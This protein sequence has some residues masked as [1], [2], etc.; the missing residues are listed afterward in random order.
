MRARSDDHSQREASPPL[1]KNRDF[2]RFFVGQFVTNAGDSLYSVAILWAVFELSGSTFLT[3]AANSLLLLPFLLQI[4]AGPLIDRLPIKHVL[5]GT[6]VVQ[7]GAILVLTVAAS[8]GAL[9]VPLVF[10]TIP[11]LSLMTLVADPLRA[12]VVPRIVPE[13]QLSRSNSA[14]TTITHGLDM[15][16]DA[17]GGLLIAAFGVTTLFLLD[18]FTF[19]VAGLLFSGM[20]I[21]VVDDDS[22]GAGESATA[23]YLADLREGV[24]VLRGTVFVEIMGTSAVFNF[25]VGVTLAILPAFGEMLGGPAIYGLLLGALGIGRVVGSVSA[26]RLTHLAY[27]RFKPITYVFSALLWVGSVGSPSVVLTVVLFG[28]AWVSAGI[29]AV[30]LET[31]SQKV[32]PADQLGR[33][34]AIKG[35]VSTG[36]LPIGSLVG[37]LLAEQLGTVAT[38]GL[39]AGGFG[40]A[41][42]YFALRSPLRGVPAVKDVGPEKLDVHAQTSDSRE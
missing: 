41:G 42:L 8:T 4:A 11:V 34:S 33:V 30:M 27:G 31:L 14:L 22:D 29:D 2:L 18:T 35:T 15:V 6:Q 36:T 12:T 5:V 25:A 19:A 9:S 24:D 17:M 37:G 28:L 39:A 32:F 10:V 21:P 38:M 40:F 26:S 1:W 16:F 7:G 20:L 3:G 13:D 23:T